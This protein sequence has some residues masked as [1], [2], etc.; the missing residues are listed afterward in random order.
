MSAFVYS[1]MTSTMDYAV[2]KVL[3]SGSTEIVKHIPIKG[4]HGLTNRNGI[5]LVGN[6]TEIDDDT[7]ELLMNDFSFKHH[8]EQRFLS[9]DKKK[10]VEK[11]ISSLEQRDLSAP[12]THEDIDALY[13]DGVIPVPVEPYVAEGKKRPRVQ[14]A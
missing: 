12:V 4:G 14:M 13:D 3:P 7:L 1:T 5:M 9:I 10:D 6:V 8:L 11:A 2:R